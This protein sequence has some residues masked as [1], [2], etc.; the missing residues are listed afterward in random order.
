MRHELPVAS[1][2]VKSAFLLAGLQATASTE[3]VSPAAEPRSHR[4]DA[5]RAGRAGRRS[6]GSCSRR[7]RRAGSRSTST[8]PAIRRRPRSS[9]SPPRSRPVPTSCSRR[10]VQPDAHRFRRRAATHGRRHRGRSRRARRAASR[11]ASCACA[12]RR[13]HGTTIEGDEIPNVIDEIPA[14][15]I[16]AAFADGVTDIRDAAELVVKESNRIGA[17]QQELAELGVGVEARAD[18]LVDPRW[19]PARRD[20]DES[21]RP[22]HRDGGRRRRQRDRRRIDRARL[23]SRRVVVSRVRRA[24]RRA[25]RRAMSTA[26][27]RRDRR[28]VG[29]GEVDRRAWRRGALGLAVLDTGAMYRAVTLRR[30]RA[31]S[32]RSTTP[33]ACARVA[34]E[35]AHHASSAGVTTLDGRDV[36]AEIRGPEVTAAVSTVAAHPAVRE[37]LV[38][39]QRAVGRTPRRRSGRRAATSARS[40]SPTR[41]SRS[42]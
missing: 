23:A 24:P 5:R 11:S 28:A 36:S 22:P 18:G 17:L 4:T 32:R 27:R 41:P 20:L 39:Q 6:T 3:V 16:A 38:A 7:G 26:T 8:F 15:A 34:R 40:C 10:V 35:R 37:V 12:R 25:H 14:L 2:Q 1:A 9:R 30:T 13:L 33:T 42:S 29:L 21:R 19:S 31:S